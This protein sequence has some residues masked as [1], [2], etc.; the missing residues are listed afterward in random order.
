[1]RAEAQPETRWRERSE[2]FQF[3]RP[4]ERHNDGTASQTAWTNEDRGRLALDVAAYRVTRDWDSKSDQRWQKME[5]E[6]ED[7]SHS[8]V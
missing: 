3:A 4:R 1:M 8:L 5:D 6:L 7:G 2:R